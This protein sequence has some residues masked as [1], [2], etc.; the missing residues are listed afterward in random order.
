VT[1]PVHFIRLLVSAAALLS[2]AVLVTACGSAAAPS[3]A[4][5]GGA[6]GTPAPST[7]PPAATTAPAPA[8]PSPAASAAGGSGAPAACATSALKVTVLTVP[9]SATA[10]TEHFP[11]DFTNVS[12]SSCNLLGYPGVSFVTG[13]GGSQVG[14][15]AAR[16]PVNPPAEVIL[17][18]GAT[19]Y[20][21]LSVVDPGVYSPS[22]CHQV[23]AH[24]VRVYPPNQTA[25]IT[26]G[27]TAAVC[28]SLPA[29][30]GHQ[31]AVAVVEPGN[32]KAHPEP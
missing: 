13:P 20:A 12:G 14:A 23:T 2:A 10:G 15:A 8:T 1:P 5:E 11:V 19:A 30:L 3:S 17:A 6:S 21:T 27:F 26:V 4:G 9:G 31:L 28:Q 25:S 32:G 7:S 29:R 24:W 18:P 22:A 16:Q